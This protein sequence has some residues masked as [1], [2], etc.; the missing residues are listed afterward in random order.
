MKATKEAL[1]VGALIALLVAP[2]LA[3]P[4]APA[5]AGEAPRL[6]IAW[7]EGPAKAGLGGHAEILVPE[8]FLFT[9]PK[10]TKDLLEEMG[11]PTNGSELGLLAPRDSNWFVVFE[12]SDVGYV[13]DDEKDALDADLI[14]ENIRQ[15]TAAANEVRE[16]RG[17]PPLLIK[18]WRVKP[19]YNATTHNLEWAIDAASARGGESV[20]YN[21][22]LLGRSGVMEASLVLAPKDLDAALPR[23]RSLLGGYQFQ[24]GQRYADWRSGD[25]IASYGLTA[26]IAGG[27][28]AAAVKSGLLSKIWKFLVVGVV[29]GLGLLTRLLKSIFSR[30]KRLPG[31]DTPDVQ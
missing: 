2:V 26:L 8:G 10:G 20:N 9:G 19:N 23:F 1:L 13:K 22:R 29:A 21:V 4:E 17:I 15:G 5:G 16:Q 14:L 12:F 25:K 18:G 28:G 6:E 3:E 11:N 27:V 30:E 31:I 7:T 24:Q